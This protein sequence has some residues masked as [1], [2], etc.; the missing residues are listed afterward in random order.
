[1][2]LNF[3]ATPIARATRFLFTCLL[4]MAAVAQAGR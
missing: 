2:N 3:Q 1:M 4:Y